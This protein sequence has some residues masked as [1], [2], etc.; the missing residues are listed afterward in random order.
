MVLAKAIDKG[1]CALIIA[2]A[3]GAILQSQR[4]RM[5][6]V[7]KLGVEVLRVREWESRPSNQKSAKSFYF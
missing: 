6:Y 4:W 7:Q 5:G 1:T 2:L 3:V